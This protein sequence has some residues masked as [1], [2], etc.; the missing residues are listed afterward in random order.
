MGTCQIIIIFT[1]IQIPVYQTSSG[2]LFFK[3]SS[4]PFDALTAEN[5]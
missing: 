3:K 2:S 1:P 4:D 5:I